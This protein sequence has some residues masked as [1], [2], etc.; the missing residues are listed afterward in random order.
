[1]YELVGP[2]LAKLALFKSGAYS[3]SLSELTSVE[4]V[5]KDG[6]PR[7]QVDI[8]IEQ[9]QQINDEIAKDRE[10]ANEN[11]KAF[12]DAAEEQ[13]LAESFEIFNRGRFLNRR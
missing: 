1:M 6:N 8:L 4:T 5:D 3:N 10:K 9:L 2:V 7:S 12:T 13:Q 11:E